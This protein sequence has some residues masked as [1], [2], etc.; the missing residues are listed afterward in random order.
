MNVRAR[1]VEKPII[2]ARR[3]AI[4][5]LL[6][7][8]AGLASVAVLFMVRAATTLA[9]VTSAW[10]WDEVSAQFVTYLC[11]AT[12]TTAILALTGSIVARTFARLYAASR[13]D[14]LTQVANRRALEERLEA[15]TAGAE[16]ALPVAFMLVDVDELKIINDKEG[17]ATGDTALCTVAHVLARACRARDMVARWGGDEFAVVMSRTRSGE[18]MAV[19]RRIHEALHAANADPNRVG[20]AVSVSIGVVEHS[21]P[22]AVR[23]S[24]LFEAA[25]RALLHAKRHGRDCTSVAPRAQAVNH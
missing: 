21:V 11:V 15:E 16:S 5:A 4:V 23:S 22:R 14:P 3:I 6:S 7:F 25:D 20:P 18:A 9:S 12:S 2:G 24:E 1:R 10:A 13:T 8:C 19:A 17:H